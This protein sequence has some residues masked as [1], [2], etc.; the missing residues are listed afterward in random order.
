MSNETKKLYPILKRAKTRMGRPTPENWRVHIAYCPVCERRLSLK[1]VHPKW[2]EPW[3][4]ERKKAKTKNP[5]GLVGKPIHCEKCGS[6]IHP[7]S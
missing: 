4:Y 7:L 3:S 6:L 5:D 2:G 1:K